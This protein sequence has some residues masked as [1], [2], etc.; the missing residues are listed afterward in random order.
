MSTKNH[1]SYSML[2]PRP[3]PENLHKKIQSFNNVKENSKKSAWIK[4]TSG[5]GITIVSNPDLPTFGYKSIHG[6]LRTDAPIGLQGYDGSSTSVFAVGGNI[7]FRPR[8]VIESVEV[9][10]GKMG[11]TRNSS[12]SIKVF[13][14]GQLEE[15]LPYFLEPG[16]S[17]FIEWGWN[18]PESVSQICATPADMAASNN[19]VE[20][21]RKRREDGAYEYENYLGTITGGGFSFQ[22]NCWDIK[23]E[24]VGTG[25]LTK[26]LESTGGGVGSKEED[27]DSKNEKAEGFWNTI[28]QKAEDTITTLKSFTS[29]LWT[30]LSTN[31]KQRGFTEWNVVP[32]IDMY[33]YLPSEYQTEDVRN[34]QTDPIHKNHWNYVGFGARVKEELNGGWF[35]NMV[36]KTTGVSL[37]AQEAFGVA[38]DGEDIVD[39]ERFIRFGTL[40]KIIELVNT[41]NYDLFEGIKSNGDDKN[42]YSLWINTDNVPIRAFPR[43]F[44]KSKSKLLILNQKSPDFGFLDT[45]NNPKRPTIFEISVLDPEMK[46][47]DTTFADNLEEQEENPKITYGRFPSD[48]PLVDVEDFDGKEYYWGYLHNLYINFDFAMEVLNKTGVT[49]HDQLLELLN[50]MSSAVNNL[51]DFQIV[52]DGVGELKQQ[53]VVDMNFVAFKDPAAF[54]QFTHTGANTPFKSVSYS[55][56]IPAAMASQIVVK[57]ATTKE[58]ETG[59]LSVNP[60]LPPIDPVLWK[61]SDGK[62]KVDNLAFE[63]KRLNPSDTGGDTNKTDQAPT[64]D[65]IISANAIQFVRSAGIFTKIYNPDYIGDNSEMG[66]LIEKQQIFVGTYNDTQIFDNIKSIDLG[67][68]KQLYR[69]LL[70]ISFDFTTLGVGGI[71]FGHCFKVTDLI[72]KFRDAGVFQIKDITHII[73]GNNWDVSVQT[74]FRPING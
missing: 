65:E 17:I 32:F 19:N 63:I 67:S 24:T 47:I 20:A 15:I 45:F 34:L 46:T 58:G 72:S 41:K 44:S 13:T 49:L 25:Q 31:I 39:A 7:G 68:E 30:G 29:K 36:R 71:E 40:M 14:L 27:P 48:K 10:M 50:G 23:I 61:S 52:E 38:L 70:P 22:D 18:T 56:D 5:A 42:P 33:G 8:P 53:T 4:L 51:W 2:H 59:T 62:L 54:G 43:I 9:K 1:P 57:R 73:S 21:Y 64:A 37:D 60:S 66:G 16:M 26:S 35:D 3:M 28:T 12:I 69:P 55:I 6:S 74:M 11:I